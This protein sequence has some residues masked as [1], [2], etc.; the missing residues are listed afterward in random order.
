MRSAVSR[1]FLVALVLASIGETGQAQSLSQ[2]LGMWSDP[3]ATPE[4]QACFPEFCTDALLS[5]LNALLDD[6][7][8]DS[9]RFEELLDE[10]RK[11]EQDTYIAP[12]L[13]SEGLRGFPLSEAEDR[14]F[15][16]V[17]RGVLRASSS[18]PTSWKFGSAAVSSRCITANGTREELFICNHVSLRPP[19]G[20]H[21]TMLV[22]PV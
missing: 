5:R 12:H 10:A 4:G 3:P 6:P 2:F 1:F 8:N 15:C 17:N 21:L 20:R 14:A 9:R 7:A 11:Y 13:T 22:S 19:A 16:T 18:L